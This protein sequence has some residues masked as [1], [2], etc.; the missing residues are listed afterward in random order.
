MS[1]S[2]SCLQRSIRHAEPAESPDQGPKQETR[3]AG[4]WATAAAP[5]RYAKTGCE[6]LLLILANAYFVPIAAGG[7]NRKRLFA[8]DLEGEKLPF[9]MRLGDYW[10]NGPYLSLI[11]ILS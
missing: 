11:H 1:Q 5:S 6:G 7:Q 10:L 2:T 8:G 9:A 3:K 4:L